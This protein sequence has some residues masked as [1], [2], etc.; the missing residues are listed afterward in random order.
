[1]YV[2]DCAYS[3]EEENTKWLENKIAERF[4][5]KLL[6]KMKW[7]LGMEIIQEEN[8]IIISQ[9]LYIKKLLE[10]YNYQNVK[11]KNMPT[12]HN[13]YMELPNEDEKN[14]KFEYREIIGGLLYIA[15]GTRPDIA[16]AVGVASRFVTN[17]GIEQISFENIF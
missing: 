3:G 1:M 16:Y 8:N 7:M 10:K 4:E 11:T 6:G 14:E 12:I 5:V 15:N 17:Y 9:E 2:D 13:H